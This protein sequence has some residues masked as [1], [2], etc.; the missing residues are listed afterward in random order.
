MT[1]ND[2]YKKWKENT[3]KK[4]LDKFKER[5]E[6]F[7]TSSGIEVP[8]ISLPN[9]FALSGAGGEVEALA[10][11]HYLEKLNFP[12]EYPFTRGV[13]PTMYRSRFWTMRQYAGFSTAEESNQRYRYLLQTGPDRPVRRLRPADPDRLR[14]RRPDRAGRGGQ[15]GRFD[16]VHPRYGAALR[17]DPAGQG[18]HVDDHQR[19][20]WRSA[21]DVHRGG[22]APGR[23][24]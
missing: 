2:Q 5:K 11:K 21:G 17:P 9:S 20:G 12:G 22:Q 18:L 7:E 1:I 14:R 13:Q 19:P 16:L 24:T 15:G 4:S 8:R 3:L 23:R 10:D 6:R